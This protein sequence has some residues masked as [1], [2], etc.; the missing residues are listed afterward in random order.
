[1]DYMPDYNLIGR[2]IKERRRALKQTQENL[3]EAAGIGIQHMSKTE[4]GRTKLSLPCLIALANALNV[5]VDYLLMDNIRLSKHDVI[6][7]AE[8][9]FSD[10]TPSEIFIIKQTLTVLKHSLREKG[11]PDR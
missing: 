3:A 8:S 10:C 11:L 2:R 9:V 7:D 6:L 4:N 5:T 1:M